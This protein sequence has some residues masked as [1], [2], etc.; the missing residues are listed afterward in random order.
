MTVGIESETPSGCQT[1][2]R[3]NEQEGNQIYFNN[4]QTYLLNPS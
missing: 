1:F 2:Q 3:T 4:L